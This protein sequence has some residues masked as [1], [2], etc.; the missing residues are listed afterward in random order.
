MMKRIQKWLEGFA[1]FAILISISLHFFT[2]NGELFQARAD[3]Q[4]I[5]RPVLQKSVKAA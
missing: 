1:R 2:N 3:L 4:Y 5:V